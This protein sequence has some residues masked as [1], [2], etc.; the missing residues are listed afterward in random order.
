MTYHLSKYTHLFNFEYTYISF[1]VRETGHPWINFFH[2]CSHQ[3]FRQFCF[4]VFLLVFMI[5]KDTRLL[6]LVCLWRSSS[7]RPSFYGRV[8]F[9]MSGDAAMLPGLSDVGKDEHPTHMFNTMYFC[10]SGCGN[11]SR[12]SEPIS[13]HDS[14]MCPLHFWICCFKTI[15]VLTETFL[16]TPTPLLHFDLKPG[17]GTVAPRICWTD[18]E[19]WQKVLSRNSGGKAQD[20]AFMP[21]QP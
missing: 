18:G 17:Y 20:A 12:Q 11:S 15:H 8:F 14:L 2:T 4:S 5:S 9:T 21:Y 6:H 10:S 3:V 16:P 7:F 19:I 13:S 1:R